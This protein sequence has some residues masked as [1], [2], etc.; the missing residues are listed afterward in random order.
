MRAFLVCRSG[1]V[2]FPRGYRREGTRRLWKTG[3]GIR[4]GLRGAIR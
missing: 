1:G 4:E 3:K 2:P